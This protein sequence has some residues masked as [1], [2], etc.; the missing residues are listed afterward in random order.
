[1]YMRVY[2]FT[3]LHTRVNFVCNSQPG[4]NSCILCHDVLLYIVPSVCRSVDVQHQMKVYERY[5]GMQ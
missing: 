2:M 3:T 1:M 5:G 4:I